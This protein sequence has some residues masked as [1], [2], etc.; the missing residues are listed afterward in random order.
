MINLHIKEV[1]YSFF[2]EDEQVDIA[3][4]KIMDYLLAVGL[5]RKE[6]LRIR[7]SAE[8]IL[9][10]W[11]NHFGK[12]AKTQLSCYSRLGQQLIGLKLDGEPYDPVNKEDEDDQ[13]GEW[14][15][16][17]LLNL[18]TTPIYSYTRNSN[19]VTF[20][21]LQQKKR[22]PLLALLLSLGAAAIV[23]LIG[24]AVLPFELSWQTHCRESLLSS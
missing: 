21:V 18:K 3:A 9:L 10:S 22:N 13:Y 4:D 5:E 6:A 7:L 17:L 20:K 8:E 12:T 15:Q 1:G 24:S 19:V 14:S 16:K 11:Q 2:L 23:G